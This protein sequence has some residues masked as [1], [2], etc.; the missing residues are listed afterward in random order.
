MMSAVS[1]RTSA[2]HRFVAWLMSENPYVLMWKLS[3][4]RA[5]RISRIVMSG[6]TCSAK[7]VARPTPRR[8]SMGSMVPPEDQGRGVQGCERRALRDEGGVFLAHRKREGCYVRARITG[9][10]RGRHADLPQ[11]IAGR[12]R[13][14]DGSRPV[15]GS[16]L[17]LFRLQITRPLTSIELALQVHAAA[18]GR[19]LARHPI[20]RVSCLPRDD[21]CTRRVTAPPRAFQNPTRSASLC[22]SALIPLRIVSGSGSAAS[23]K[24]AGLGRG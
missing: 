3:V 10:R 12:R 20:R 17:P 11:K 7:P 8:I 15:L 24:T 18:G 13:A 1:S 16:F 4:E 6:A 9:Q 19:H 2:Y 21:R 22:N 23:K 14:W 5:A